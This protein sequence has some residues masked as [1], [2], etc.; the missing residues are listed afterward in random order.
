MR[1]KV[2]L[3]LPTAMPVLSIR[4]GKDRT[5]AK[6]IIRKLNVYRK[7]FAYLGEEKLFDSIAG[8][9]YS[10]LKSGRRV[11]DLPVSSVEKKLRSR[12]KSIFEKVVED[13][14]D[15]GYGREADKIEDFVHRGELKNAYLTLKELREMEVKN[16]NVEKLLRRIDDTLYNLSALRKVGADVE[17]IT[18]KIAE[19]LGVNRLK[20]PEKKFI[21]IN[22]E[23]GN[24]GC[25][26][27]QYLKRMGIEHTYI[28]SKNMGEHRISSRGEGALDPSLKSG[29]ITEVVKNAKGIVVI[30]D[31]NYLVVSNSFSEVYQFLQFAKNVS[32]ARIIVTGSFKLLSEREITRLRGLFDSVMT[33]NT[34]FNFCSWG[35]IGLRSRINRG[36]LLLSKE[37]VNDFPGDVMMIADFG[38]EKYVHPQRLDFEISDAITRHL[39]E[40]DVVIDS[41]D[42]MIDENGLERIYGWMK[43]IRDVALETGNR[44]YVVLGSLISRERNYLRP[45]L[46]ADSF[47]LTK[48]DPKVLDAVSKKMEIIEKMVKRAME[49]ECAYNMEVIR[50]KYG[51]YEKHLAAVKQDVEALLSGSVEFNLECLLRTTPLRRTIEEMVDHIEKKSREF[52][53]IYEGIKEDLEIAKHYVDTEDVEYCVNSAMS[54]MDAGDADMALDKIRLCRSKLDKLMEQA[55]KEADRI[56]QELQCISELLP[57]YFQSKLSRYGE[58]IGNMREF[59]RLYEDIRMVALEKVEAEYSRLKKY[60]MISGIPLENM[61]SLIHQ[62]RFCEYWKSRNEFLDEFKKDEDRVRGLLVSSSVKVLDF[63]DKHGYAV[64]INRTDIENARDVESLLSIVERVNNH[65]SMYISKGIEDLRKRY[66]EFVEKNS[67]EVERIIVGVSISPVDSIT[68]YERLI[69]KLRREMGERSSRAIELKRKLQEYYELFRGYGVPVNE[70][71]PREIEKAEIA[72]EAFEAMFGELKPKVEVKIEDIFVDEDYNCHMFVTV[73]N[74]GN[75]E[76]KNVRLEIYGAMNLQEKIGTLS[77]GGEKRIEAS[78]RVEKPDE[79]VNIDVFYEGVGGDIVNSTFTFDVNLRGYRVS[80][81]TGMER[82]AHCRGRIVKGMDMVVCSECGA[83]Y[84]RQCA[85]RLKT[86]KICGNVFI[87]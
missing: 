21:F 77:P 52:T 24:A 7:I 33:L 56:N 31:I 10:Q 1:R 73:S 81:A 4:D 38:G 20:I 80:P 6:K 29:K 79:G 72:V 50:Q 83:T 37:L 14:R 67:R 62:M 17:E 47:S 78:S 74:P 44:V 64:P 82:C 13:L 45:L 34:L 87:F 84:H 76:A 12:L 55:I 32:K 36:S 9:L 68:R 75:H 30:E 22:D 42:L 39:S 27:S 71:Y 23:G 54:T 49:K 59:T 53:E 51:R 66:P 25:L 70:W 46:D 61:D 48:L 35:M 2:I 26:V 69:E 57:T 16:E 85:E 63:L 60:S 15:S 28:A 40:G 11:K 3:S 43:S 19:L 65:L 18:W 8:E 86:C 5:E 58:G 41:I